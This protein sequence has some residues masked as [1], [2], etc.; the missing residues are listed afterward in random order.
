MNRIEEDEQEIE[1]YKDILKYCVWPLIMKNWDLKDRIFI[2]NII[3]ASTNSNVTLKT[4]IN[5]QKIF[6][7]YCPELFLLIFATTRDP[8]FFGWET[9]YNSLYRVAG[10]YLRKDLFLY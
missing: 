1:L 7:S 3:F 9:I 5:N 4:I 10:F 8:G 6:T 2:I